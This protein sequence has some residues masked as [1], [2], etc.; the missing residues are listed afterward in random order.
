MLKICTWCCCGGSRKPK[1]SPPIV[2][3]KEQNDNSVQTVV[4]GADV[5]TSNI[6]ASAATNEIVFNQQSGTVPGVVV[7]FHR[8]PERNAHEG[9]DIATLLNTVRDMVHMQRVQV[10]QTAQLISCLQSSTG[11]ATD[12][13]MASRDSRLMTPPPYGVRNNNNFG[14]TDTSNRQR[15]NSDTPLPRLHLSPL[16]RSPHFQRSNN[17]YRNQAGSPSSLI[18]QSLQQQSV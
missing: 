12:I 16:L 1:P 18:E 13:E 3:T 9:D 8:L 7:N 2:S 10:Q 4:E 17:R 11:A 5:L 14:G 15:R 6:N